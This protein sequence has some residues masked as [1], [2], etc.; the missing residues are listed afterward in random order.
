MK[1]QQPNSGRKDSSSLEARLA[2]R[3]RLRQ[4]FAEI[5]DMMD[6]ALADGATADQAEEM[7]IEQLRKLGGDL[8]TEWGQERHDQ[9]L[10]QA[11]REHPAA[12][13]HRK[14]K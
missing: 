10:Q 2:A 13:R 6:R 11:Q 14:K 12:I 9:A 4:R 7:A 1:D 8:M 3:P 5:M